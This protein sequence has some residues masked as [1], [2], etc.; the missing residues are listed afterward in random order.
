MKT[1]FVFPKNKHTHSQVK[2]FLSHSKQ[3]LSF[4]ASLLFV[5]FLK[6]FRFTRKNFFTVSLIICSAFFLLFYVFSSSADNNELLNACH[7]AGGEWNTENNE[8]F[9]ISSSDCKSLKG[10]YNDCS[11]SCLYTSNIVCDFECLPVCYFDEGKF[12]KLRDN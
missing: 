7:Q 2:Q 8:C 12:A 1:F 5:L 11:S 6:A 4:C 3:G 10:Q 9:N